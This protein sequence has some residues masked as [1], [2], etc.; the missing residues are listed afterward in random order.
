MQMFP[1]SQQA[2]IQRATECEV[3]TISAF[4]AA[5]PCA[6]QAEALKNALVAAASQSLD[7]LPNEE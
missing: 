2:A 6:L 5:H 1:R 7:L 3:Q 4:G